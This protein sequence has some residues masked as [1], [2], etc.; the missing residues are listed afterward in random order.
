MKYPIV[1]KRARRRPRS[2]APPLGLIAARIEC[3]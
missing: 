2:P 1:P 3:L